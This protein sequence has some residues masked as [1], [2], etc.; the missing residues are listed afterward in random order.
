MDKEV[1]NH[2]LA[3]K[4]AIKGKAECI[5]QLSTLNQNYTSMLRIK[6][7]G[8]D[9]L[10][11]AQSALA[12]SC[13]LRFFLT[14]V[15]LEFVFDA[16]KKLSQ[17]LQRKFEETWVSYDSFPQEEAKAAIRNLKSR[18]T[19]YLLDINTELNPTSSSNRTNNAQI[20]SKINENKPY[21][22]FGNAFS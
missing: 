5:K 3:R 8:W 20:T 13:M 19:D 6:I 18:L 4:V 22:I 21:N 16:Y 11:K 17:D 1:A 9:V 2:F 14:S 7:E 10:S 15:K 12:H